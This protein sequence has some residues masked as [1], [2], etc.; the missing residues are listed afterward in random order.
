MKVLNSLPYFSFLKYIIFLFILINGG[1]IYAQNND[2]TLAFNTEDKIKIED[3]KIMSLVLKFNNVSKDTLSGFVKLPENKSINF[4]GIDNVNVKLM[5]NKKAFIPLKFTILKNVVE[6]EI[7]L[8][9]E[10]IDKETNKVI[11]SSTTKL[12]IPTRKGIRI[13]PVSSNLNYKKIGDSIYY[14]VKVVNIGNVADKVLINSTYSDYLGVVMNENKNV[15]LLPSEEKMVRFSKYVNYDLMKV[16]KFSPMITA[17]DGEGKYSGNFN[18]TIYNVN[19]NKTFFDSDYMNFYNEVNNVSVN[20]RGS[21]LSNATTNIQVHNEFNV[22][23][24][25][26][27]YNINAYSD[28]RFNSFN[29]SNLWFD[30]QRKEKG[31]RVGN[32]S[33]GNLEIPIYGRGV[34]AY[35]N[36]F[37]RNNKIVL[38]VVENNSNLFEDF[39]ADN[40]KRS[41]SAFANTTFLIRDKELESSVIY[42]QSKSLNNFVFSN[43][44]KWISSNKWN[45]FFKMAYGNVSTLHNAESKSSIA[46][47][48]NISGKIS[49]KYT[50]YS[51]NYYS[52]P[53]YI[54]SRRGALVFNQRLQRD[55]KKFSIYGLAM[56]TAAKSKSILEE[57]NTVIRSS[58]INSISLESGT[59]F[60]L[61]KNFS[62]NIAPKMVQETSTFLNFNYQYVPI[63]LNSTY[64]S[65]I[66]YFSSNSR[67]HQFNLNI[68]AGFSK[69]DELK[70]SKSI[71]LTSLGW[72]Y[73][74][75]RLNTVLQ[76]GSFILLDLLSGYNDDDYRYNLILNYQKQFFNTKL[77][78]DFLTSYNYYESS[79][80][81]VT[82]G[83]NSFYKV[84]DKLKLTGSINSSFNK[85]TYSTSKQVYYQLGVQYILPPKSK[86]IGEKYGNLNAFI[87]YDYNTNGVFD[88]GDK[89]SDER[90]VHINNVNFLTDSSGELTY[91]KVPYGEYKISIPGQKWYA[92]E[93]VS[94]VNSKQTTIAIPMQLTGSVKG[95]LKYKSQ[96]NLEVNY[97][98]NL[99]AIVIVFVNKDGREIEIKTNNKGE[100]VAYLPIGNYTF[101]IKEGSL[102]KNVYPE[103]HMNQVK[104]EPEKN[105]DY[106]LLNLF[107][108]EKKVEVRKFGK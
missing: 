16:D 108:K 8:E 70:T 14:D 1:I 60:K 65:S 83:V 31:F 12:V 85:S 69:M 3:N 84:R 27:A 28:F 93:V 75:F 7:N 80:A 30:Y 9:F 10:F 90:I 33:Y 77:K 105:I 88:K 101:Y 37:K 35:Q 39:S 81:N 26:Y 24:N 58:N 92:E 38:G 40:F 11:A 57:L 63:K 44:Y 102:Q 64:L 67:E 99:Y 53:Y 48:F 79:A 42:Q 29:I 21:Q 62:V 43:E 34:M 73:R 41:I 100:Y 76:K 17:Y 89:V 47:N 74:D 45:Y 91:K 51:Y 25:E 55:F 49:D 87:Y 52:T 23:F 32:I 103:I 95:K 5:P 13:F 104:I 97:I 78:V 71:Y 86:N 4:L 20:L 106:P 18:Y 19:S 66:F 82:L 107:I 54:G 61:Y 94:I 2:K 36:V 72:S 68:S 50:F 46:L 96:S 59:N 98:D 56:F 22:G 6:K 15:S